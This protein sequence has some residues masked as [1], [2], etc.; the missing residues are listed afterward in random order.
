VVAAATAAGWTFIEDTVGGT[1]AFRW[2]RAPNE[3]WPT[4]A[5]REAAIA[6]MRDRMRDE[7]QAMESSDRLVHERDVSTRAL[8]RGCVLFGS[9]SGETITFVW[10]SSD[11]QVGPVFASRDL[12]IDWMSVQLASEE[13]HA[14]PS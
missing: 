1:T 6:S 13:R 12:A 10:R 8:K 3:P 14:E 7:R 5:R 11:V 2:S 9:A 4:F